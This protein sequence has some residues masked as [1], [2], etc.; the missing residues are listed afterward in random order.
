MRG[1]NFLTISDQIADSKI[2]SAK[3][4]LNQLAG[5]GVLD[6]IYDAEFKVFSEYGE[7]GIIQYLIKQIGVLGQSSFIELGAENYEEANTRFL[8]INNNWRGLNIDGSP[9]NIAQV[10]D[11]R[12][13]WN[14]NLTAVSCFIDSD[15]INL[16]FAQ[17]GFFKEDVGLLSIDID[18]NDYWVWDKISDIE[19]V[20]VIVEFNSV[21]GAIHAVTVPY[22]PKFL[23]NK[24]HSSCLYFGASLRALE[25]LGKHKCY[26]LVGCNSAGNNVF[27]VLLDHLNGIPELSAKDAYDESQFVSL[28][29]NLATI[30][31]LRVLHDWS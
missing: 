1:P 14:S 5:R 31:L 9:E 15:N 26:A 19:P 12:L 29:M 23:R 25:L 30:P 10:R 27:F 17:N 4:L 16:L 6:K 3:V 20:I 2:L 28:G 8:L 22:D 24:A 18:G 11:T 13:C 21:F 7:D